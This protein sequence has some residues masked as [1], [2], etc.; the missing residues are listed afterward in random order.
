MDHIDEKAQLSSPSDIYDLCSSLIMVTAQGGVI[1]A[2]LSVKTTSSQT[3]SRE[4]SK[5]SAFAL[6]NADA[7]AESALKCLTYLSFANFRSGPAKSARSFGARLTEHPFL[8]H[9]SRWWAT[10][11]ENSGFDE[12]EMIQRVKRERVLQFFTAPYRSQ[13]ESWLQVLCIQ[14]VLTPQVLI[15]STID[16][17]LRQFAVE[18]RMRL[19]NE[20]P[21]SRA[22]CTM[23]PHLG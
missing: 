16:H 11:V 15:R 19:F 3:E 6:S 20:Y 8:D 14:V 7:N 1:L 18:R 22:G 9:A 12:Q 2:H 5:A 17:R 10:Y 21:N 4:A 13:V 23:R